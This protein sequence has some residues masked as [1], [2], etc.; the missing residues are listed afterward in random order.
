[1]QDSNNN[2]NYGSFNS[3]ANSNNNKHG[4]AYGNANNNHVAIMH[5]HNNTS[6]N[7][8]TNTINKQAGYTLVELGLVLI[9]MLILGGVIYASFTALYNSTKDQQVETEILQFNLALHR[10]LDRDPSSLNTCN[11]DKIQLYSGLTSTTTACGDSWSATPNQDNVAFN[12]P[13]ASCEDSDGLG[14]SLE[15]K[16]NQLPNVDAVYSVGT[17]ELVITGKR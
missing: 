10:C 4:N 8:N 16:I 9:I 1:M 5:R 12:Y 13:L 6:P 14:S 3:N 11:G 2:N 17:K 7:L 15:Q